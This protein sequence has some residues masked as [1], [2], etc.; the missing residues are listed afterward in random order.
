MPFIPFPELCDE[1]ARKETRSITLGRGGHGKLPPGSYEFLEMYC[2]EEDCDCRRVFFTVLS[3]AHREPL[4]VIAWGWEDRAFYEKW[5]SFHDPAM[6]TEMMG[7]ALNLGSRQSKYA[8]ELL[9][10]AETFLLSD[11]A[12]VDRI[13]R[14]YAMFRAEIAAGTARRRQMPVGRRGKKAAKGWRTRR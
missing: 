9:D 14:H 2:D 13:K 1:V 3:P 10:L 5:L 6:V 12:Y 8:Q 11:G 7:P 4:A